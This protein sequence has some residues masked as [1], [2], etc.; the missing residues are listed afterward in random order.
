MPLMNV[1]DI[2]MYYEIHGEGEPV[3]LIAG[4][5]SDLTGWKTTIPE[6]A[7]KYRV[8]A[9]DTRGAGR[10]DKPDIPYSIEQM[11]EDTVG[12]MDALGI[13]QA[14]ILGASMG[15]RI[16]QVIARKYPRR[17]K[18]LVLHVAAARQSLGI[19]KSILVLITKIQMRRPAF[20]E[21]ISRYPPTRESALRQFDALL[22]F[23]S[24]TWLHEIKTPTL[25]VN[26]TKD[27]IVGPRKFT[28]ELVL[29]IPGAKLLMVEGTHFFASENPYLLINPA[30]AFIDGVDL[31]SLGERNTVLTGTT[32][33]EGTIPGSVIAEMNPLPAGGDACEE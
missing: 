12:L 18:S 19:F 20:F 25:V 7:R 4:I 33:H 14:H 21:K 5:W 26:G 28:D 17:V 15:A 22:E 3:V 29:G 2:T 8:I 23:D 13:R 31:H 11:A 24:R 10:T 1:D 30:R 9:L 16:A 6:L 32:G 27:W